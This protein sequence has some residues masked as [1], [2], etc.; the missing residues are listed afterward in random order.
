MEWSANRSLGGICCWGTELPPPSMSTSAPQHSPVKLGK[1]KG[2][3]FPV[4]VN[5]GANTIVRR[6]DQS[7]V[8]I[9]YER[10]FR[11]VGTSSTPTNANALAQF[12]FCGCGWPQ[13][14][15]IP[16]GATGDGVQFDIFAMVSDYTIDAINQTQDPNA[17]CDDAHSFCGLRDKLYP[18]TRAMGYPFDRSTEA[19]VETLQDFVS[20][21]ANMGT[22]TI[23]VRFSNTVI[24]RT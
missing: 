18:D 15:L 12:R 23:R 2:Q 14:M 21:N 17:P 10:T 9:P 5:P 4:L 16:K 11:A 6:S 24:A 22:G 13:H 3:L 20:P 7:S 1:T 19:T 8:T